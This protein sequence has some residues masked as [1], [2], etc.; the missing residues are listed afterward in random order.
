MGSDIVYLMPADGVYIKPRQ[1]TGGDIN[2][3]SGPQ[4]RQLQ[5]SRIE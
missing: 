2:I 1:R 4:W 5:I 3:S